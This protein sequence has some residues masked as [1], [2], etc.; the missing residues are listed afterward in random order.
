MKRTL[1]RGLQNLMGNAPLDSLNAHK[2]GIIN[3]QF[4]ALEALRPK[5]NVTKAMSMEEGHSLLRNLSKRQLSVADSVA[6]TSNNPVKAYSSF[7]D[8]L[9]F[10]FETQAEYNERVLADMA[11]KRKVNQDAILNNLGPLREKQRALMK[12]QLMKEFPDLDIRGIPDD[13][14]NQALDGKPTLALPESVMKRVTS[15]A[16]ARLR[17]N[18]PHSTFSGVLSETSPELPIGVARKHPSALMRMAPLYDVRTKQKGLDVSFDEELLR[19]GLQGV[20]NVDDFF[21]SHKAPLSYFDSQ[22]G[23]IIAMNKQD[24][25]L[26]G[27]F[28]KA[29]PE[30]VPVMKDNYQKERVLSVVLDVLEGYHQKP[31]AD[32]VNGVT[33]AVIAEA[34]LKATNQ[35]ILPGTVHAIQSVVRNYL[36]AQSRIGGRTIQLPD[37]RFVTSFRQLLDDQMPKF[38][39]S[40]NDSAFQA[41][42]IAEKMNQISRMYYKPTFDPATGYSKPPV[43]SKI[44]DSL[45]QINAINK[46]MATYYYDAKNGNVGE[47][48]AF[49][50]YFGMVDFENHPQYAHLFDRMERGLPV[51]ENPEYQ[52]RRKANELRAKAAPGENMDILTKNM[53]GVR[54]ADVSDIPRHLTVAKDVAQ[55]EFQALFDTFELNNMSLPAQL[56]AKHVHNIDL[57][58]K[59]ERLAVTAH[60]YGTAS[61][62]I[63]RAEGLDYFQ[64]RLANTL[65]R[66]G[67]DDF[68]S[69]FYNQTYGI[70]SVDKTLLQSNFDSGFLADL[71]DKHGI[72]IIFEDE[73]TI[74]LRGDMSR[75]S[76]Y[77]PLAP[78]KLADDPSIPSELKALI[79]DIEDSIVQASDIKPT[80]GLLDGGG[81]RVDGAKMSEY[82]FQ[83][84][85]LTAEEAETFANEIQHSGLL[86]T[87]FV[88]GHAALKDLIGDGKTPGS[89]LSVWTN[90]LL[91]LSSHS[92]TKHV[93]MRH[94]FDPS[95][96]VK[97]VFGED[98]VVAFEAFNKA[99]KSDPFAYKFVFL[100][101]K[102]NIQEFVP[103]TVSDMKLAI[104]NGLTVTTYSGM[105]NFSKKLNKFELNPILKWIDQNITTFYK[106]GYFM[107]LGI[108]L[109]NGLDTP[110]KALMT[111]GMDVEQ[112]IALTR[113]AHK[114]INVFSRVVKESGGLL[115]KAAIDKVLATLSADERRM[116]TIM[117]MLYH[118]RITGTPLS[119]IIDITE[120]KRLYEIANGLRDTVAT[121]LQSKVWAFPP[122]KFVLSIFGNIEE[123]LRI[124]TALFRLNQGASMDSIVAASARQFVDYSYKSPALQTANAIIPFVQFALSNAAFWAD[125]ATTNP[126]VFKFIVELS[127]QSTV[128]EAN[129]ENRELNRLEA[130]VASS[131]NF[132]MGADSFKW[133]PSMFDAI[134]LIPGVLT[135]PTQ[136]LNP[137]I[138]NIEKAMAGDIEGIEL[139]FEVPVERSYNMIMETIP[140]MMRGE[141]LRL[142]EIAPSV[143]TSYNEFPKRRSGGLGRSY[144][145]AS[146]KYNRFVGRGTKMGARRG[147]ISR[148][149]LYPRKATA[150]T[151]LYNSLYT[152]GGLSRMK[153]NS[154][155]TTAKNLKYKI[156]DLKYRFR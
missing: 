19:R 31:I 97:Y 81:L 42:F 121:D 139:P 117:Q 85:V 10:R 88:G 124:A 140:K 63:T 119:A 128:T 30:E 116:F 135:E 67:P 51:F 76:L 35:K 65:V 6:Q 132:K 27:L 143:V 7:Y 45:T 148:Y 53:E 95:S 1:I 60:S 156:A 142:G 21:N 37:E 150:S 108:A 44:A 102:G 152:K 154:S 96:S 28:K 73:G 16:N 153:L 41:G 5:F 84:G 107:N 87:S 111:E 57:I 90:S 123:H 141:N 82:L 127:S 134:R 75:A 138:R 26:H 58:D 145:S 112:L 151:S 77:P 49:H 54:S 103:R 43:V 2:I 114:H 122:L 92:S 144:N 80:F 109:R 147:G 133:N 120:D 64:G 79:L 4:Q 131:G 91:S 47:F 18:Y 78:I 39:E 149:S 130:L 50:M 99:K 68:S 22:Q 98:P 71:K 38:L 72:S 136:R 32:A 14:F 29:L 100:N 15:E 66:M 11:N 89:A 118:Y 129:R 62:Y 17:M 36:D 59:V 126:V 155:P 12:L 110:L 3:S 94:L 56:T 23:K 106:A 146:A 55:Q 9:R 8:G 25:T 13:A 137:V 70:L 86:K 34:V 93:F 24:D 33:D 52:A 125:E 115:D 20:Q 101:A 105:V 61:R 69:F 83:K 40:V 113:D 48:M 74:I 46:N 104:D